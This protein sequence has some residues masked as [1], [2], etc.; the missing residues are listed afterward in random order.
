MPTDSGSHGVRGA[1]SLGSSALITLHLP[2]HCRDSVLEAQTH[3]AAHL[4]PF[5][6][7]K[8]YPKDKG[9]DLPFSQCYPIHDVHP[10]LV[11]SVQDA[12]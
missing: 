3:S 1:E 8:F 5:S 4:I 6:S 11:P 7:L 9:R 12:L 2:T 10:S